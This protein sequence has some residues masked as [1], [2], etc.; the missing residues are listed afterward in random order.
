MQINNLK[1]ENKMLSDSLI[2][3][4]SDL[5]QQKIVVFFSILKKNFYIKI[6]KL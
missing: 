1:E 4:Q 3:C 5:E 2:L 6:N